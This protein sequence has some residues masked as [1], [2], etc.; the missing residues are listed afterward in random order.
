MKNKKNP[1]GKSAKA[2]AKQII[3]GLAIIL[4]T[5]L[6]VLTLTGQSERLRKILAGLLIG[7]IA[8]FGAINI[9]ETETSPATTDE[10]DLVTVT[11][12]IDG[13]TIEIND[14]HRVRLLGI[15]APDKGECYYEEAEDA[16]QDLVLEKKI[17]L[18]KDISGTD[19]FG[20]LLRYVILPSNNEL[21]NDILVNNY[22]IESGYA[23]ASPKGANRKYS[24]LFSAAQEQAINNKEGMWAECLEEMPSEEVEKMGD[25]PSDPNCVIKG[26]ISFH[27]YGKTYFT[28]DCPNYKQTKINFNKGEKYFCTEQ[29]AINAG[30][31]KSDTCP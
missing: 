6:A 25:L 18:E 23:K 9:T 11:R 15:N 29:E 2:T 1:S 13:D 22:L 21:A 17:R 14:E 28:P 26:N 7:L 20:R 30:F 8:L 31:K 24:S 4:G 3:L 10:F 12:V 27:D 19:A 5:I 16:L